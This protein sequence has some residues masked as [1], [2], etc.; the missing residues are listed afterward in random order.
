MFDYIKQVVADTLYLSR[1]F[2]LGKKFLA[3]AYP[4]DR[5]HLKDIVST[6]VFQGIGNRY[7]SRWIETDCGISSHV[8]VKNWFYSRRLSRRI[9]HWMIL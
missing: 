9:I 2:F 3:I 5:L 6:A 4:A 1:R 7:R 8:P